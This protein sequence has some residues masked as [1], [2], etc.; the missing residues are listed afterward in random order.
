M[1]RLLT[2]LGLF[3]VALFLFFVGIKDHLESKKLK[4]EG[5]KTVAEVTD[6]SERRGRKGRRSYYIT[7][8]FKTEAGQVV[9]DEERVS[10]GAYEWASRDRRVPVIYAP[11]NPTIY[12]IGSTV[13][14]TRFGFYMGA[15]CLAVAGFMLFRRPS[16]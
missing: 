4:A 13:T 1:K 9:Q 16:G 6:A 14:Q 11:S 3:V 5:Q 10:K 2:I 12:Q 8:N 7:V 15:G